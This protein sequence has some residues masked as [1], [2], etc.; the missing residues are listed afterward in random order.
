M[1]ANYEAKKDQYNTDIMNFKIEKDRLERALSDSERRLGES[2]EEIAK[3]T[4][5]IQIRD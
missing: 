4:R 2:K 5:E 1:R 3:I